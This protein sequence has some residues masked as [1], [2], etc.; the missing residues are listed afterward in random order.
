MCQ[1]CCPATK[2]LHSAR[3]AFKQIQLP[4]TCR[5]ESRLPAAR[6]R[7]ES[8]TLLCT[9]GA[10]PGGATNPQR[11]ARGRR[12]EE[13]EWRWRMIRRVLEKWGCGCG[14]LGE[15]VGGALGKNKGGRGGMGRATSNRR[16]NRWGWKKKKKPR[17]EELRKGNGSVSSLEHKDAAR[18]NTL[19]PGSQQR[20]AG[21]KTPAKKKFDLKKR[22]GRKGLYTAGCASHCSGMCTHSRTTMTSPCWV[23]QHSVLTFFFLYRPHSLLIAGVGPMGGAPWKAKP[24]EMCTRRVED[25]GPLWIYRCGNFPTFGP[26]LWLRLLKNVNGS[27][28]NVFTAKQMENKTPDLV[29]PLVNQ[30]GKSLFF[31]FMFSSAA[32]IL[33]VND[34]LFHQTVGLT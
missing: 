30:Q 23:Q 19:V 4:L 26:A 3:H 29:F 9:P 8:V 20:D 33:R 5:L 1:L 27:L 10:A 14:W 7:A 21:R 28:K 13:R 32:G 11:A 24:L 18:E 6:A 12:I 22:G 2:T 15:W 25:A 16:R 17:Q 31:F 34:K